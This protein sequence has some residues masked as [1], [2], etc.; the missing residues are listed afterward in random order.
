MPESKVA[1]I[2]GSARGIGLATAKTFL[3]DGWRVVLVDWDQDELDQVAPSLEGDVL[4]LCLDVSSENHA[5]EMM[6]HTKEHFG[7]I[8]RTDDFCG[9]NPNQIGDGRHPNDPPRRG[10]PI[11]TRDASHSRR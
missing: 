1:L 11:S 3:N 9:H 4:P 5:A 10:G 6:A 2:T 8:A 7:R